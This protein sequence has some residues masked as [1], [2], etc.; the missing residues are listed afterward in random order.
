MFGLEMAAHK[1]ALLKFP[2]FG[3]V[4]DSECH[5]IRLVAKSARSSA[6]GN[7]GRLTKQLIPFLKSTRRAGAATEIDGSRG[8][9]VSIVRIFELKSTSPG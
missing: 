8:G 7:F 2:P 9:F 1:A 6:N 4:I 3:A 5:V